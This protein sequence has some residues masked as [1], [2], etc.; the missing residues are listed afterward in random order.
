MFPN[1]TIENLVAPAS[2]HY[3]LLLK[4]EETHLVWVPRQ[5]FKFENAWCTEPGIHDIVSTS[6]LSSAGMQVVEKLE[7][8]A[9]DLN[10]WSKAHN[11]GL[12]QEI[13]NCRRNLNRS[14]NRGAATDTSML[15]N[16]RKHMTQLMIQEDKYWLQRAKTHWY[17]DGD[18]NTKCFH[19]S[20]TSGKKVNHINFLDNDDGV[21]IAEEQ[22]MRQVAKEYFETLF[23]ESNSTRAPVVDIIEKVV[24]DDDNV[25]LTAP[26]QAEEFKDAMFSMHPDKCPDPDGFNPSFFQQFWYVCNS[27]IFQECCAWLNH[28][29]F[30]LSLNSTNITLIPKGNEQKTMK[31]LRPIALCNGLYKLVAKVLANRLKKI[32]HKCISEIQSAFVPGRSILNNAMIAIE[33][34][35]H[36]K[37]GK[38]VRDKNVALKLDISKAYDTI[39]WL[40]LKEVMLKMGFDSKWA[41]WIMMCVET[42]DYSVIVNNELV[43]P[44]I[45]GRG[46][47]QGD[48]LSPYLFILCAEGLSALIRKAERSG[49]LHGVSICTNAPTISHLLFADDCFLFFRA[50]DNE[51]Q[52]MKN[53]LH[54]Y[55]LASGQ[56]I[57]LPKSEVFFSIVV[58]STL[59][60]TITNILG[61]RAV[62]GTSKYLRLPSMVGRSKEVAF[63]FIKDRIWHKINSWSSKCLS[64]AG[65]EVMIKSVLQ[66]IP[67]HI[68]SIFLLPNKLVNAIEKMINAFWWG[69]GGNMRRGLH[70][71]SWKDCPFI[72]FLEVSALRI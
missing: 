17:R 57:S 5:K 25:M 27:D 10:S 67:S 61:V 64:K 70:W 45:P 34:V 41:Q 11:N 36:M 69:H 12:K 50:D 51:A 71:M 1:V 9:N 32:L 37:V 24:S 2:D 29:H 15:T 48:P 35:H 22:G 26:F 33:V 23:L 47:R 72:N 42:V 6:W 20:A 52:V 40:Y 68:M 21:R 65:R 8:C 39:D 62:M 59:K 55:E 30:P 54:T 3:P 46:L 14:R 58:P 66:S 56:T 16:L 63:G 44:I 31:D 60:D 49:D 38:R 43:G 13:E 18:L 28:N 7:V 19:A 53:I 4:K